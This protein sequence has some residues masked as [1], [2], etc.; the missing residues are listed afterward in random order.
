MVKRQEKNLRSIKD[1]EILDKTL[2]LSK[3]LSD[4]GFCFIEN[5]NKLNIQS[6]MNKYDRVKH[7]AG[8][9]GDLFYYISWNRGEGIECRIHD[10]THT[11]AIYQ[12]NFEY[13]KDVENKA[14]EYIRNIT[15]KLQE[16]VK[17]NKIRL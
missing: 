15:N 13:Y 3:L 9:E 11:L 17:E 16:L 4:K 5:F 14:K 6:Y 10:S 2:D 8:K 7:L 1:M 12:C